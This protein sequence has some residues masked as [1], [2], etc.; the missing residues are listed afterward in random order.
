MS[1]VA[2]PRGISVVIPAFDAESFVESAIASVRAQ[3]I[4]PDE[5][6]LADDGSTDRTAA[7][8][9]SLGA[10]VLRLPKANGSAARNAGAR[11]AKSELLFFL[12]VDDLWERDKIESHLAVWRDRRPSLVMDRVRIMRPDGSLRQTIGP[13][14]PFDW[15]GFS[16]SKNWSCGSSFS[17]LTSSY[18]EAGA[19]DERLSCLQDLDFFVRALHRCGSGY[20]ITEPLTRYRVVPG[21]VSKRLENPT[22]IL[23]AVL[24]S[25][26]FADDK[27]KAQFSQEWFLATARRT[28]FPRS[29][30]YIARA[31]P[32]AGRKYFWVCALASVRRAFERRVTS[33]TE[34]QHQGP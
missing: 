18:W 4:Q 24:A 28:P 6:I 25:W 14:G 29:L 5:I 22:A 7:L 2:E 9:E 23:S 11:S 17:I 32:K 1:E 3:T 15:R 33:A 16:D 21:S 31:L 26:D 30:A 8:G 27:F 34:L 12:D 13:R 20:G 19:F 10:N